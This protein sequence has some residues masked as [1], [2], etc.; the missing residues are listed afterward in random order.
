MPATLAQL[1]H[2][3]G[4]T[5]RLLN[6]LS[7]A[8]RV[9]LPCYRELLPAH[10]KIVVSQGGLVLSHGPWLTSWRVSGCDFGPPAFHLLL[11]LRRNSLTN[12][13]R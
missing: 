13:L 7:L 3:I 12:F 11:N 1:L 2:K 4:T 10:R 6:F 8:S 9:G 5:R